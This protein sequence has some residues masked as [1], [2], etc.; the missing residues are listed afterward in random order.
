MMLSIVSFGQYYLVYFFVTI[1]IFIE[2]QIMDN[3][4]M[5][6]TLIDLF[7]LIDFNV[8]MLINLRN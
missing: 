2:Y 3:I 5:K 6:K 8:V 1:I 7:L 4:L